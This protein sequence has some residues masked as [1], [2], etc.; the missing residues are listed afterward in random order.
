MPFWVV[1]SL[2]PQGLKLLSEKTSNKTR[3]DSE[4]HNITRPEALAAQARAASGGSSA[5]VAAQRPSAV[6]KGPGAGMRH[7]NHHEQQCTSTTA[8]HGLQLEVQ[9]QVE[10]MAGKRRVLPGHGRSVPVHS[11]QGRCLHQVM[12]AKTKVTST[13]TKTALKQDSEASYNLPVSDR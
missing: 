1:P 11:V 9:L 12:S 8:W 4:W 3:S 6:T 5:Q 7:H 10:E 2:K 13:K